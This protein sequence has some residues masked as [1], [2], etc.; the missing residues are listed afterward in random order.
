LADQFTYKILD[1]LG[2][3]STAT[4]SV[5]V[6]GVNDAPVTANDSAATNEDTAI[7]VSVANGLVANDTDAESDILSVAEVNGLPANVGSSFV[8]PS[9]ATLRVDTA[10]N[11]TYNPATS[12]TLGALPTGA[13]SI[14][15][16]TYRASDGLD[17]STT[18][19]TVAITVTGV[20]DRPKALADKYTTNEDV[21]LVVSAPG[22]LSN[23]TDIDNDPLRVTPFNGTSSRGATISVSSNGGFSYNPT[24]VADLQALAIGQSLDD[25]FTYTISDG[26]GG[27]ATTTVTVTVTGANDLPVAVDDNYAV[28]EDSTLTVSGIGVLGNDSDPDVTNVL[29]VG[30]FNVTSAFGAPVSVN[31]DGT[32]SYDPSSVLELQRLAPGEFLR[33]TFTYRVSD[34][35]G[36]SNEGTVTVTV[37][38]RNDAPIPQ[39]DSY[40]VNE[41]TR[42]TVPAAIGVLVNDTD[43]EGSPLSASLATN[44]A[45][46]SAVLNSSGFFTYQPNPDFNGSDSFTYTLSDGSATARGTVT[47]DVQAVNDAP[48]AVADSY[49]VAEGDTLTVSAANGLLANDVDVDQEQLRAILVNG[50]GPQ[51][52]T[53]ALNANGSFTYSPTD[54]FFGSD[55][56]RYTAQDG[57][58]TQSPAVTVTIEVT[59]TRPRRNS[60]QPLDVSA[61]GQVSPIDVLLIVNEINRNGSHVIP[62]DSPAIAPFWDVNGN[63]SVDPLD[64]LIVINFLNSGS[65]GFAEG[66]GEASA[67]TSSDTRPQ[68]VAGIVPDNFWAVPAQPTRTS[69]VA[70]TVTA[71]EVADLFFA[72]ETVPAS[73]ERL[74]DAFIELVE[75]EPATEFSPL[76]EAFGEWL[77]GEFD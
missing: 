37:D 63:G 73:N 74:E 21:S 59:N 70:K 2:L 60:D 6:G 18:E 26:Q 32:F 54:G 8:L 23:D 25:T 56:F 53:L 57:S 31:P 40:T 10:G 42:L 28:D 5:T 29:R 7:T 27:S 36:L 51:N 4:V 50:S 66:E 12:A 38:G 9:G 64:A 47:I 67:G 76:D 11:Y 30:T 19:G 44:P 17:S 16:F 15:S 55:T 45:N 34:G 68:L 1:A 69:A 72:A 61:D 46:G 13:T 39:T 20:N 49:S 77:E 14:D 48:I 75:L 24:G 52:G 41:D 65:G 22:L 35:V 43:L 3:E 33:D 71:A 62:S 58:G